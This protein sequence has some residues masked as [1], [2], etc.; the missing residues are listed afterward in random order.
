[1]LPLI[2]FKTIYIYMINFKAI[3]VFLG[4]LAFRL[5]KMPCETNQPIATGIE[6]FCCSCLC[7]EFDV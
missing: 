4:K 1:M 7:P 6:V 5:S 2:Y 3:F